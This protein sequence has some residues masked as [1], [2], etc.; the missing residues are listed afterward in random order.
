MKQ[1]TICNYVITT[2]AFI[3]PKK[4]NFEKINEMNGLVLLKRED[5]ELSQLTRQQQGCV[6]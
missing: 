3:L 6:L 2:S 4:Q 1:C 5:L